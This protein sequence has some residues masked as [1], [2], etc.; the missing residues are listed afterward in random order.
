[1][2]SETAEE[3]ATKADA[4]FAELFLTAEGR[5]DPYP[6]YHRLRQ[7]EPVHRSRL[8]MWVLRTRTPGF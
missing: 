1:M 8:G 5:A 6:L 2:P 4:L 3:S 7:A